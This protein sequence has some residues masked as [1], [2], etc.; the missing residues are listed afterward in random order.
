MTI[1]NWWWY[2]WNTCVNYC[3]AGLDGQTENRL[4]EE[5]ARRVDVSVSART[6]NAK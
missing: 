2:I 4:W 3:Y 6:R 5:E 1:D